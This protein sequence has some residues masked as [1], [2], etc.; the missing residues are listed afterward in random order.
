MSLSFSRPYG[1]LL[2]LLLVVEARDKQRGAPQVVER[3]GDPESSKCVMAVSMI[4]RKS[5]P[6]CIGKL[7][8]LEYSFVCVLSFFYW[9]STALY[10]LTDCH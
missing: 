6:V 2:V 10:S 7:F 4:D 1:F 5:H 8:F 9:H 3:W